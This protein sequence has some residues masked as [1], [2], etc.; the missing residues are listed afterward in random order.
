M[1][2]YTFNPEYPEPFSLIH[3]LKVNH[4]IKLI[5]G[6]ALPAYINSVILFGSSLNL[7][8]TPFGDVDLYVISSENKK[9]YEFFHKR[10]KAL[11]IKADILVSDMQT[12]MEEALDINAIERQILRQ[13]VVIYEKESH[14]A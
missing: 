1:P 4:I 9:A 12:F 2:F 11:K 14:P 5:S 13:G 7:T 10:C 6:I 8:C 3:P